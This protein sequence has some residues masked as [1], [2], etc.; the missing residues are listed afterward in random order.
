[1]VVDAERPGVMPSAIPRRRA[2]AV[3]AAVPL[4]LLAAESGRGP[5]ARNESPDTQLTIEAG[6]VAQGREIIRDLGCSACHTIPG[7]P[8]PYGQIGPS[9]DG[10]A[11]RRY[12]GGVLPNTSDNLLRWLQDPPAISPQTV[13][14]NIGISEAEARDIAAYLGSLE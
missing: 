14:P 5:I 13:M 6:E 11:S 4:V 2:L 10:F 1:M 8:G 12:I 9:L 7:V 3:L